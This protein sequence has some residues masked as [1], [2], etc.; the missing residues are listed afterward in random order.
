MGKEIKSFKDEGIFDLTVI[1]KK[2]TH[3]PLIL[4][5]WSFKRKRNHTGELIKNKARS[6]VHGGKQT[7]GFYFGALTFR[8]HNER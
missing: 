8:G 7:K 5:S 1:H 4:F 6:C 3:R 2:P